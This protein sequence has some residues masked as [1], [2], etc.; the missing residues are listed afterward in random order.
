MRFLEK[1]SKAQQ[2]NQSKLCIGLDPDISKIPQK[3][4]SIY[5]FCQS[6]IDQTHDLVCAYKPNLGFFLQQGVEGIEGLAGICR[7]IK[8]NT[9]AVLIL[10][11][12]C[13][14]IG[15]TAKAYARGIFESFNADAVTVNP[16]MGFDAI[17][18]FAE[19]KDRG[20]FV[21][22]LTSNPSAADFEEEI[23]LKVAQKVK[24]WNKDKNLGLVVGATKEE[25]LKQISKIAEDLPILIPGI[26]AQG[27]DIETVKK[28]CGKYPV[29]N[30]SR[31]VIYAEDPREAAKLYRDS[32]S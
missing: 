11:A 18:P 6:I 22:C 13:G 3:F 32:L 30:V 17:K 21:L 26:G 24:D 25:A 27:G 23:Y 19:Y 1:L 4:S 9:N 5:E 12:K 16:Y 28:Y 10:D 15:N 14:D 2:D 7:D 29:I 20:V 31:S 8:E